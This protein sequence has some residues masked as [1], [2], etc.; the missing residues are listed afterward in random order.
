MKR[1]TEL[2]NQVGT[3]TVSAHSN[4]VGLARTRI[5]FEMW[6]SSKRLKASKT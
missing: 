1:S 4:V 2:K 3:Y 6:S 5:A